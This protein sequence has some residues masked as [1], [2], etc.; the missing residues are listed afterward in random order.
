MGLDS[1]V[2]NNILIGIIVIVIVLQFVVAVK[3]VFNINRFKSIFVRYDSYES[4]NISLT[5][6]KI[7]ECKINEVRELLDYRSYEE[8]EDGESHK[9][10]SDELLPVT[11]IKSNYTENLTSNTIMDS[12]NMYLLKN[13]G[14]AS[15]FNLI[16]NIVDRNCES[17]EEVIS[18]QQ[19]IPLYLGLVGTMLGIIIGVSSL[20]GSD[21]F[22]DLENFKTEAIGHLMEGVAFAMVASFIGIAC[23]TALSWYFKGA[24][25]ENERNKNTFF[26]WVQ[27]ELIPVISSNIGNSLFLLQQ[28]LTVFNRRFHENVQKMDKSLTQV[29]SSYKQQIELISLIES[30]DVNKMAKANITVLKTLNESTDKIDRFNTYLTTVNGYVGKVDSLTEGLNKHLDR[31]GMIEKMAEFFQ[32]EIQQIDSRKTLISSSVADIDSN[33]KTT[34]DEL[35]ESSENKIK[36]LISSS[37]E[38]QEKLKQTLEEQESELRNK[39]QSAIDDQAMLLKEKLKEVEIFLAEMTKITELN[40]RMQLVDDKMSVLTTEAINQNQKLDSVLGALNRLTE[41][42]NT[43]NNTRNP[44]QLSAH[45]DTTSNKSQESILMPLVMKIIVGVAAS[46]L[47]VMAVLQ[48]ITFYQNF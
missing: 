8:D 37:T 26:S 36:E 27:A 30:L 41:A 47:L 9:K 7:K 11:L 25:S 48:G 3:T 35:K 15:D 44:H 34:L 40:N 18:V 42:I 43:S 28:N 31:T 1:A 22:Q 12:I 20:A 19:P 45:Q 16:K 46:A 4:V 5:D 24:K 39:L 10:K 21:V 14:S 33:L 29:S 23:T 38:H 6:A 17:E 13:T 32:D 2:L